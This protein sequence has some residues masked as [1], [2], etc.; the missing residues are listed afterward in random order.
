MRSQHTSTAQLSRRGYSNFCFSKNV[1]YQ[2]AA[3]LTKGE[4][5]HGS[6]TF[7]FNWVFQI[8]RHSTLTNSIQT[9]NSKAQLQDTIMR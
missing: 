2:T 9:D 6:N 4:L 8:Y 5:D 3:N 7:S 1:N